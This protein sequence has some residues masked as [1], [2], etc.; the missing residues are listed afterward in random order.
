MMNGSIRC[1]RA[2]ERY[3]LAGQQ[4]GQE[5]IGANV[6]TGLTRIGRTCVPRVSLMQWI[7]VANSRDTLPYRGGVVSSSSLLRT[8]C[9]G[10]PYIRL[11]K[12]LLL[13]EVGVMAVTYGIRRRGG[14]I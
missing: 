13:S 8:T 6:W 1:G 3:L 7:L 10:L 12:F 2:S 9:V 4:W 5:V 11:A 14:T